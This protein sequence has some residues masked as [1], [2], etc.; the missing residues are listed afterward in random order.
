MSGAKGVV[1]RFVAAQE[2]TY[3]AVLFD[4]RQHVAPA[5]QD[6][7]C[8]SLMTNVPNQPVVRR[9]ERIMQR[10]RELDRTERSARMPTYTRHCFQNV[11]TDFLGYVLQLIWSQPA[12]VRRRVNLFQ[13]AHRGKL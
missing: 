1:F 11:L 10:Y 3:T 2:A 8:I 13:Q 9:L 7:V 12:Q 6:L 5:R 4:G